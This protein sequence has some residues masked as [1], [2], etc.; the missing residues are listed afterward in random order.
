LP[1][2][3]GNDLEEIGFDRA[4]I[5]ERLRLVP[6]WVSFRGGY[7]YSNMGFTEGALAAA[8]TTGKNWESVAEDSLYKPLGMAATS[9]RHSDFAARTDRAALHISINGSWVA[10]VKR[11]ADAQAPAGGVSSSARD[12][13]QWLRLE[14]SNGR[15]NGKQMISESAIAATHEPLMFRGKN[16]VS[17]GASFY[18]LGWNVEFG[19]HGLSWGHAGAFSMGARTLV[20]IYPDA[21]FGI[22]ILT[23][24]F[25]TGVPEGISD[26][27]ADLVF[28]GG[29][30]QD[31]VS[32]W[33]EVFQNLF[34]PATVATKELYATPPLQAS[35]ALPLASYAGSYS[36]D[37]VGAASVVEE[38][39]ALILK[40]GP[41]GRASY[42]L[43]HFDRDIFL[44]YP[45]DELADIPSSVQFTVGPDGNA[46]AVIID[47]M[48]GLGLGTLTRKSE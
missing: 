7:S 11:T 41:K 44:A 45:T 26:S 22:V 13:A 31:W 4:A 8:N 9:S 39:G 14:L 37:Y 28:D 34:G 27:F 12:L 18:G 15:Y 36:N 17:G 23:N 3:A 32:A 25:P 33:N 16:P 19:R 48:N 40:L 43:S 5:M 46:S 47:F 21:G 38:E 2:D 35:K 20:T 10:K 42:K 29:S 1:G 24:G 6:A 30:T